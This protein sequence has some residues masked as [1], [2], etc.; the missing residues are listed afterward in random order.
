VTYAATGAQRLPPLVT[1]ATSDGAGNATFAF[2]PVPSTRERWGT[3]I[4]PRAP[5]GA[6]FM[7]EIS[8]NLVFSWAGPNVGGPVVVVA[9]A[10]PTVIATG[11]TPG[12]VYALVWHGYEG[13]AGSAELSEQGGVY[14]GAGNVTQPKVTVTPTGAGLLAYARYGVSSLSN[15]PITWVLETP[16][17]G[18]AYLAPLTE[19]AAL[20]GTSLTRVRLA[21]GLSDGSIG[22]SPTGAYIQM[23][24]AT[25]TDVLQTEWVL[26]DAGVAVTGVGVLDAD[27]EL[28]IDSAAPPGLGLPYT[29]VASVFNMT[30]VT[31]TLDL[32]SWAKP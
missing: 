13:P 5:V 9:M 10:T 21:I 6:V 16:N 26:T 17:S 24:D 23:E 32:E 15:G 12:T 28:W 20:P 2:A 7:F 22:A 29:F 18:F 27:N 8:G 11:L 1:A 30:G 19:L 14:P 25:P 4:C 3:L 31:A